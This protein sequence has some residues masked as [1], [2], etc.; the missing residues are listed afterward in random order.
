MLPWHW[1]IVTLALAMVRAAPHHDEPHEDEAKP[2]VVYR[3]AQVLRVEAVSEFQKNIIQK[4]QGE[5]SKFMFFFLFGSKNLLS[6]GV[7]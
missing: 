5:Q 1:L 2:Q 3:G 6:F 7:I 4:M